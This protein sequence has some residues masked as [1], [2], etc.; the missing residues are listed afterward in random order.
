MLDQVKTTAYSRTQHVVGSRR[1]VLVY[2]RMNTHYDQSVSGLQEA[3][4]LFWPGFILGQAAVTSW[5]SLSSGIDARLII[6][7][8]EDT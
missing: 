7:K 3:V 8:F 6:K 4:S 5:N 1:G 2:V